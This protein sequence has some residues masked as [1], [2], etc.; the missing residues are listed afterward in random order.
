M[1]GQDM[2]KC[3]ATSPSP[4]VQR[5]IDQSWNPLPAGSTD[6]K[7]VLSKDPVKNPINPSKG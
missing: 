6:P 2:N 4:S 1:S 7:S 5:S 3:K